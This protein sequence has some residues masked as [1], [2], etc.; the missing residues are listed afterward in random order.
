MNNSKKGG[1]YKQIGRFVSSR[2][3]KRCHFDLKA[4]NRPLRHQDSLGEPAMASIIEETI[5][6]I[7]EKS[8]AGNQPST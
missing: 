2:G 3:A 8:S 5:L 7:I 4:G 1:F 6:T